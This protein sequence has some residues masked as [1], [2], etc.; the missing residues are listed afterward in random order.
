M[1]REEVQRAWERIVD[2][3]LSDYDQLSTNQKI[4]FNIEPLTTDGIIDHY[5]NNGAEHNQDTLDA[6]QFLGFPDIANQMRRINTLFTNGHP[7]TDIHE[8]NN[9]WNNWCD[10]HETL[11]DEVD[12]YFWTKCAD[13]EKAILEHINRTG[14][15]IN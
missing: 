6:L 10:E 7:P 15:G 12:T 13:L 2:I 11:L 3:G 4:W 9:Q 8:R 5:I 14:I 1:T